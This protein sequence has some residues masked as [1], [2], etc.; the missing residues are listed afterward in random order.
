MGRGKEVKIIEG[1][2]R[3]RKSFKEGKEV[4]GKKRQYF[5][6]H[7]HCKKDVK[8][9]MGYMYPICFWLHFPFGLLQYMKGLR[10]FNGEERGQ[11]AQG[12]AWRIGGERV[13]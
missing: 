6:D 7:K 8:Y 13:R 1:L 5:N 2:R 4:V 10:T 3:R 9:W 11:A 12:A